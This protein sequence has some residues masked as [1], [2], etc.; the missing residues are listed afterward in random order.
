MLRLAGEMLLSYYGKK[1]DITEKPNNGFVTQADTASEEYLIAAL[2]KLFPEASF[3]AEESGATGAESDYCWVI[4]PLDGTTNFAYGL[5]YW[6]ISVALTH[7]NIPIMGAIYVPLS[8]EYFFAESGKGAFCNGEPI[9][10]SEPADFGHALIAIGV[11]YPNEQRAPTIHLA[12]QVAKE[13]YGIRHMGA[14]ALDL[15]NIACGRLDGVVLQGL[16]WWDVAAGIV[17]IQEAG[18][19]ITDFEGKK[20]DKSYKTGIAGGKLVYTKLAKMVLK[21]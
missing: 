14:I 15:A 6:C 2:K 11:P 18:G 16:A 7:K 1:L 8:D 10:V 12:E 21:P 17:L 4:D 20:L 9:Q 19:I 13:S 5:P 3:Y